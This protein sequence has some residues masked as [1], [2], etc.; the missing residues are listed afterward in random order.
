MSKLDANEKKS[1]LISTNGVET[2][3]YPHTKELS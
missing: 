1:Y 2:S 3:G